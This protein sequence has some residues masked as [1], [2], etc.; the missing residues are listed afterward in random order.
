VENLAGGRRRFDARVSGARARTVR[1]PRH[2][3]GPRH[4]GDPAAG[5]RAFRPAADRYR[6]ARDGRHRAGAAR[7][8][9]RLA[10]PRHVHHRLR[11]GRPEERPPARRARPFQALPPARPRRRGGP[12]VRQ[13]G[14][15]RAAV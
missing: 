4:G 15:A 6:H 13:R 5:G 10:P 8:R 2:C 7:L 12:H 9:N 3:G 11:R 14:S 1:L